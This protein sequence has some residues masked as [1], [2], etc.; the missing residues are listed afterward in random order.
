MR[1]IVI[2]TALAGLIGLAT[3]AQAKDNRSSDARDGRQVTQELT[4]HDRDGK[5]E[6]E[7]R[8]ERSQERHDE[9]A[10]KRDRVHGGED[11][12]AEHRDRR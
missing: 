9:A 12:A 2:F 8:N 10:D 6:R 4:R 7:A 5:H 11:E 3:V 1:K